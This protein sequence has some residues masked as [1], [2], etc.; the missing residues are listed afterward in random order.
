MLLDPSSALLQCF[1]QILRVRTFLVVKTLL[2]L[3][4]RPQKS[5]LLLGRFFGTHTT[6]VDASSSEEPVSGTDSPGGD[7]TNSESNQNF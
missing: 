5:R 4:K 7:F 3:A 6:A 1:V 2:P